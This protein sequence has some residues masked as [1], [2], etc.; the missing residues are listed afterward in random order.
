MDWTW[1]ITLASIVGVV[2]NIH[3]RRWC[4][5]VWLCTNSLWMVIDFVA[6]LYAQASKVEAQVSAGSAIIGKVVPVDA[7]GDEKFTDANPGSIKL[8]GR[9]AEA[10]RSEKHYNYDYRTRRTYSSV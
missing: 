3:R 4:F 8:M 10:G 2:A 6:G 5:W 7:G 9:N 1:I